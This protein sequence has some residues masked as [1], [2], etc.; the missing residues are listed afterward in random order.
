MGQTYI[1]TCR[2]CGNLFGYS[3]GGGFHFHLLHCDTCGAEK[4]VNHKALGEIHLRFIKG[5]DRPYCGVSAKHDRSVQKHYRGTPISE[6][7]YFTAIEE[8]AGRCACGG[9][10]TL[11][12][13]PRCSKCKSLE[14][15]I[16]DYSIRM[17]D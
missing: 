2:K 17:Y 3:E 11:K 5:L 4:T 15:D 10:Y 14:V 13:S 8:F 7:D 6:K 12:A 9:K 1:A 16:S